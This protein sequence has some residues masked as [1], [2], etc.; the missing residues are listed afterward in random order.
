PG[1]F[2][3][4][5]DRDPIHPR[6]LHRHRADPTSLQPLRKHLQ[7][8]RGATKT[9]Y[10]LAVP[11]RRYSYVVGFVPNIN[12]RSLGMHHLQTKIFALHLAYILSPFSAVHLAPLARGWRG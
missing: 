10:R 7:L 2:Q 8:G 1:L 9:P 6:R 12:T 4:V 3:D 11:G 5:E